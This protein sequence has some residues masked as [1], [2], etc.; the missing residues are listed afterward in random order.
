MQRRTP[1]GLSLVPALAAHTSNTATYTTSGTAMAAAHVAGV[2]AQYL[3]GNPGASNATA[4]MWIVNN[5][6]TGVISG[7]PSGTPNRLLFR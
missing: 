3:A 1:A 4:R 6:T 7:N 5:A 2:G